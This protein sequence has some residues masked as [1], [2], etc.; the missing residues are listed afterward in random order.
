MIL[1]PPCI[2]FWIALIVLLFYRSSEF[3]VTF[4]E[5]LRLPIP[6]HPQSQTFGELVA[7]LSLL[8]LGAFIICV[9][10]S[11]IAGGVIG[12]VGFAARRKLNRDPENNPP[13]AH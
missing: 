5:L 8:S 12:A 9:F 13:S 3:G 7:G 1:V 11:A 10:A 6:D 4:F 2:L